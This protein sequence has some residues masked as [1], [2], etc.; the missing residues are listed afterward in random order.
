MPVIT[1]SA[2]QCG[3]CGHVWLPRDTRHVVRCAKC[4]T[5]YWD[6]VTGNSKETEQ[7]EKASEVPVTSSR[8]PSP[9]SDPEKIPGVKRGKHFSD[10]W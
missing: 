10:T 2:H 6:T 7:V 9:K 4:K 3:K 1:V 5:P 8:Y